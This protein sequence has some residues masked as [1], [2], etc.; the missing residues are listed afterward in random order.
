MIL[1]QLENWPGYFG[2]PAWRRA[3][4]HVA[5]LGPDIAA[6]EYEISG[7]DI[8]VRVFRYLTR[9]RE[10]AVLEAHRSY[11]DIQVMLAGEEFLGRYP[12]RELAVKT[13]YDPAADVEFYAHPADLTTAWLLRPGM[14]AVFFP[15]DAHL[16]QGQNLAPAEVCKAVVKVRCELLRP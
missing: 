13:P 15:Q 12:A 4:E 10:Q 2:L 7:R 6:G 3:M 5:G 14:F 8:F 1:D 16:S 9:P 11:T